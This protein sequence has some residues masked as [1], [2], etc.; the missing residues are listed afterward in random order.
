MSKQ[1]IR[2]LEVRKGSAAEAIGLQ[3]GDQILAVNGRDIPDELA[4]RFHLSEEHILL[5]VRHNNGVEVNLHTELP[6]G[7]DLGITVEE[8]RTRTCNN[9][10]LFCFVDQLPPGVRPSLRVK[11][12]DY[13]LSFLHGNYVT[14]SNVLQK[15]LDRIIDQRLSPLYVSVHSTDPGLRAR[16]LGR[17]K[18]EDL[19]RKLN[20]LI[21][22]GIQV[23]A[24]V[25]LLP[26]INDGKRLEKTVHDLYRLYPGVQS[27]AIVPLGLSDHGM[28]KDRFSPVT[29][30]FSRKLVRQVTRWQAMF[31][32][33]TGRTFA[34]L[35][36][37]F[38]IQG[39]K[40]VPEKPHYD[41][42]AQIEDGVGM[43]RVFQDDFEKELR[44]RKWLHLSLHGTLVTGRLFHPTLHRCIERFNR[45]YGS[46]L[47]VCMVENR[48]LGGR[49]TVAGLL[50]GEDIL[51]ELKS[52]N[53]GDFIVVPHEAIS[54]AEGILIDDLSLE[55]LSQRLGKPVY[56]GG[57]TVGE[58]FRLLFSVVS[59]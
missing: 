30:E 34:Y 9:R 41:D 48:F 39:G 10:C 3:A 21:A 38:Y 50:A 58:F 8:F 33:K 56:A 54:R 24:Q 2:I 1:G 47:R 19:D 57:R 13:R 5:C 27:V 7:A 25:V 23:H 28:P 31:R 51:R 49:I 59:A 11:D 46:H 35:G 53:T 32:R 17:K 4:L 36:D 18:A 45:R 20:R 15:D 12:D 26:G 52:R 6:D 43:V 16:L 40:S 55:D 42:F 14:L 37:E 29:P 44:R 22:G